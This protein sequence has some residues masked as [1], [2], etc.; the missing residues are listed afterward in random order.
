MIT[1]YSAKTAL[2]RLGKPDEVAGA[3]LWLSSDLSRYVTGGVIPVDGGI[4]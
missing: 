4:S 2:G 3:V 1:R